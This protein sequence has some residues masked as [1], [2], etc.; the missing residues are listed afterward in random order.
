MPIT[1]ARVSASNGS[2]A[3]LPVAK[4][5]TGTFEGRLAMIRLPEAEVQET[6]NFVSAYRQQLSK[7]SSQNDQETAVWSA[8]ARVLFTSNQFLYVD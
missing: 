5:I 3:G 8:L 1:A 6:L 2:S 4:L 7:D